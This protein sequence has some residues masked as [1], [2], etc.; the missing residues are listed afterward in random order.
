MAFFLKKHFQWREPPAFRRARAA[1]IKFPWWIGPAQFTFVFVVMMGVWWLNRQNPRKT[2]PGPAV[3]LALAAVLGLFTG[4][5]LPWLGKRLPATVMVFGN[6][7][8]RTTG[9]AHRE[10][11]FDKIASFQLLTGDEFNVIALELRNG[12]RTDIGMPSD[13]DAEAVGT[14]LQ[15]GGVRREGAGKLLTWEGARQARLSQES[16]AH[17]G[18]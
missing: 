12:R 6:K 15:R 11:K 5:F 14:I 3:A 7:I 13:V 2:P 10:F 17:A 16:V 1:E 9:A 8:F 4:Y 18:S